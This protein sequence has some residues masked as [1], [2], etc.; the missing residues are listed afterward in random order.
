[1][2]AD[3]LLPEIAWM[4]R[5]RLLDCSKRPASSRTFDWSFD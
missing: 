3:G 2:P 4:Q 5:P 1:M